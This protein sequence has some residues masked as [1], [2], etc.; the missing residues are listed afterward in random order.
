[1]IFAM[2]K[3]MALRLLRDK[4][5]LFLTFALPPVIFTVLAAIFSSA[6][7]GDLDLTIAVFNESEAPATIEFMNKFSQADVFAVKI[8]TSREAVRDI[9]RDGNADAGVVFASDLSNSATAK[10]S[11]HDPRRGTTAA[12]ER[13]R[14]AISFRGYVQSYICH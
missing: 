6:S 8:E 14:R 12:I 7:G 9:V 4:G 3:V 2:F 10:I 5:V 11:G 13:K 1:M